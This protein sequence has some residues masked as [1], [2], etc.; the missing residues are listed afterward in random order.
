[1]S[2]VEQLLKS[3]PSTLKLN[4]DKILNE[5]K[6]SDLKSLN[7]IVL[8]G[9]QNLGIK[10]LNHFNEI[11]IKVVSFSD[12]NKDKWGEYINGI[13]VIAPDAIQQD[14]IVIITSQYIKPI[15]DQLVALNIKIIIPHYVLSFLYQ[16]KFPNSFYQYDIQD[17]YK[18]KEQIKQVYNILQDQNSKE[19]FF[20]FLK[21]RMS[22]LPA[23]LPKFSQNQ[24][25]P[26]DFWQLTS[27]E[28]F[29]DL[30]AYDGDTLKQFLL[31]SRGVFDKYIA[32]EP[33][34]E[35]FEK[36]LQ[37]IPSEFKNKVI[38][39][40]KGAGDIKRQIGFSQSG[41]IDSFI[42]EY[43][44]QKID[45]ITVDELF[46]NDKIST[47]KIDVKGYEDQVLSGAY[48]TIQLLKPKIAISVYHKTADIWEIPL[49]ILAINPSYKL[50][51]RHHSYDI[52]DTVLYAIEN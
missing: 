32:L 23:D 7:N 26:H 31:E 3:F 37:S 21:F 51:L 2:E 17:F 47:M 1:M 8:F 27:N 10:F 49:K 46:L 29:L 40:C 44:D 5:F 36:L 20:A 11:G 15:Y 43:S 33:D 19:T 28:V 24:Y 16:E 35:N 13:K 38:A 22:L 9:S 50:F 34:K 25:F 18:Y 45:L 4:K 48:K 41:Q 42:D 6:I 39:Y 12:N 52:Y 14:Q 30:G